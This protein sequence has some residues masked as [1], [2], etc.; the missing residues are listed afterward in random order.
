MSRKSSRKLH[1]HALLLL[2][3]GLGWSMTVWSQQAPGYGR[4]TAIDQADSRA[5]QEAEQLVSLSADKITQILENEAGLLL[6]VKKAIVRKA[7]EQGRVLDPNDLTDDALFRL[8]KED[9]NVRVIAT[10]E[11]ESRSYIRAKPTRE[12]L[13]R[14]LPCRDPL[15]E[16][17]VKHDPLDAN[18]IHSQEQLY[19]A[20]H[21][22]DL[23]CYLT[24]YLPGGIVRSLS[25]Q[26]ANGGSPTPTPTQRRYQAPLNSPQ[27]SPLPS[28][29]PSLDFRR[30]LELAGLQPEDYF[31]MDSDESQM[32]SISSD[33]LPSLLNASQ[34]SLSSA[35][36]K[37]GGIGEGG[38]SGMSLPSSLASSGGGL[39]GLLGSQNGAS[40]LGSQQAR[41]ENQRGLEFPSYTLPKLPQQPRLRH[42]PNPY[43]DIPSLYD[44]YAQYS[45]QP[46][47]LGR[48]GEDVFRKR[49]GEPRRTSHGLAGWTGLCDRS[50]RWPDD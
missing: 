23:D 12:E 11:I 48:F 20:K 50:R 9:Q 6:Q 49:H 22:S 8:I 27:Y 26:P 44:L 47:K 39:M 17:D 15:A 28:T 41:F 25:E 21:D 30:Q 2:C 5:E 46:S 1:Y 35:G 31:G 10:Q 43:A 16:K 37:K 36:P 38:S 19:W 7:F 24:Q 34:M 13:A 45:R 14:N 4:S 40:E 18:G 29:P 33:Q 3:I 32:A 42:R